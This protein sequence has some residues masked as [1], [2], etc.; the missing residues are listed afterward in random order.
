[1]DLFDLAVDLARTHVLRPAVFRPE[2]DRLCPVCAHVTWHRS[3]SLV[4]VREFRCAS[5]HLL[6]IAPIQVTGEGE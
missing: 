3:T 5:Q 2:Q 1:M 4:G 6:L